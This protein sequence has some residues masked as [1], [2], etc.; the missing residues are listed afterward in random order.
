MVNGSFAAAASENM[1]SAKA[2]CVCENVPAMPATGKCIFKSKNSEIGLS[3]TVVAVVTD[4][5]ATEL[6]VLK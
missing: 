6:L 4:V 1:I 2:M 5:A 3:A